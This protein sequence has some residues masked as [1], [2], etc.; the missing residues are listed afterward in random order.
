VAFEVS[1]ITDA[2]FSCSAYADFT[3]P[4][5]SA[6]FCLIRLKFDKADFFASAWHTAGPILRLKTERMLFFSPPFPE[7]SFAEKYCVFCAGSADPAAFEGSPN[8]LEGLC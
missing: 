5:V 6:N 7:D 1:A 3:R 8:L 2:L 4:L